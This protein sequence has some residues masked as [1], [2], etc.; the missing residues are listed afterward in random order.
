MSKLN[1][2]FGNLDYRDGVYDLFIQ[3]KLRTPIRRTSRELRD[4]LGGI[5]QYHQEEVEKGRATH[6]R[7]TF[8]AT[9]H[10]AEVELVSAVVQMHNDYVDER[11]VTA[12]IR[13]MIRQ[14]AII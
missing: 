4:V 8:G 11:K 5:V 7:M 14:R 10:P 9:S 2:T 12:V 1:E 13:E 6:L 3:A